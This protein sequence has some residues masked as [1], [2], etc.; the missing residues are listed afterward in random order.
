MKKIILIA[1][2]VALIGIVGG[3]WFVFN[4]KQYTGGNNPTP[5]AQPE[6]I[7][8]INN[9]YGF[10]FSLPQDWKNFSIVTTTWEGEAIGPQGNYTVQRGP[11]ISLRN[12]N[13][14]VQN[15]Y[16]DIPIMIFTLAQWDSMQRD[17]FHIGA[18]PINPRELGRN[19]QHV[20]ALPA[21]YNYAFPTGWEE[22]QSILD[23]HPL[24]AIQ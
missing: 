2:V 16:Q 24:K 22:V 9:Q 10:S 18:A 3:I 17:E 1:S 8:Y 6:A 12:P 20:F 15:P 4:L 7:E 14:T 5:S 11:I 19:E 13:W 23:S 21:R